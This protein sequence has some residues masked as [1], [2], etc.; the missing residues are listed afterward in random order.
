MTSSGT[1]C[2]LHHTSIVYT[3]DNPLTYMMSTAKLN[4]VGHC[5]VEQ[6]ADFHLEIKYKPG[7][8]NVDAD[9]LSCCSLDINAYMD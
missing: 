6:V 1:I 3:D 2:S 4:A 8:L 9:T 7:K 5:W